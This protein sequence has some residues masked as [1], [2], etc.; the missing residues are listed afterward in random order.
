[1]LLNKKKKRRDD[2]IPP[3]VAQRSVVVQG[4]LV[5]AVTLPQ[6]SSPA[7]TNDQSLRLTPFYSSGRPTS[8]TMTSTNNR[9]DAPS[10]ALAQ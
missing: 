5:R 1:M 7:A 9:L 8:T 6:L 4:P 3:R 10:A 2:I